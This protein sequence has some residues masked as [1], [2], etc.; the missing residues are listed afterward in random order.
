MATF[1]ELKAAR[2]LDRIA[3]ELGVELEAVERTLAKLVDL[4]LLRAVD[5]GRQRFYELVHEYLVADIA[6]WLSED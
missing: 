6:S 2:P 1:S 5:K 4:R 3:T